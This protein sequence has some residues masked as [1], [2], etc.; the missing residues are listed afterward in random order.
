MVHHHT[1]SLRFVD[2][3]IVKQKVRHKTIPVSGRGVPKGS[4]ELGI[5]NFIDTLLTY[6]SEA[7]S[8]MRRPPFTIKEDC[9]HFC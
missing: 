3:S 7:V 9:A 4:E 6:G 2:Q 1:G 8:H 5:P